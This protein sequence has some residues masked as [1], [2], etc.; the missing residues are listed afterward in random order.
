[1]IE[2]TVLK[3]CRR[4]AAYKVLGECYYLPDEK[5]LERLEDFGK[6]YGQFLSEVVRSAPEADSLDSHKVD[7]SRLF[8]GPFKLLAPPYGS[9]YL[10]DGKFM[11]ESTFA[12]R[13]LYEQEGLGVV[14][15]D[16]P[17]HISV[18]LEFMY[19]LVLAEAEAREN[20]D[21]K[22][23]DRLREKQASFLHVHLGRW[24]SPF[25][26]NIEKN[27]QTEFYKTLGLATMKFVLEELG[28]LSGDCEFGTM[29]S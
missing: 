28:R 6:A 15:K 9:V 4:A 7:Y 14:L 1:M 24:V 26:R 23:A 19:F 29:G 11:S 5:L 16:A 10:E 20:S 2:E 21:F 12:A 22:E 17:D 3:D 13:D 27:T 8:L 18:E 25:A